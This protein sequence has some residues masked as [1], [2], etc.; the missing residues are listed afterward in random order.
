MKKVF[1]I[2]LGL[3]FT[4]LSSKEAMAQPT[5]TVT[6]GNSSSTVNNYTIPVNNF[7]NYSYT[8]QIY[9]ASELSR[10]L[11]GTITLI[12]FYWTGGSSGLTNSNNWTI[13]MGHTT[14]TAFSSSTVDWVPNTALTQVFQGTVSV[15]NTNGWVS[16]LLD[17][18]FVYNGTDNLVVAAMETQNGYP[19]TASTFR[20]TS[21]SVTRAMAY[22]S[23]PTP[24]TATNPPTSSNIGRYSYFNN[25]QFEFVVPPNNTG[26]T[27]FVNPPDTFCS[28][29][30]EVKV[31]VHNFGSNIVN[32]VKV[33]WKLNGVIQ[34]TINYST[35]ID[36]EN[37]MAGPDASITLATVNFP[38]ATPVNIQ[39]WTFEPNGVQDTNK[40]NDSTSSSISAHL[41][42][43]NDFSITP[44][45]T[46]IC[47][48]TVANLDAGDHPKNPI[49]I[50][51][52]G[53]ITR[54]NPVGTA[55]TYSVIVQNTDGCF[56]YDTVTV[57]YHDNPIAH[58]IAIE[59]LGNR[60]FKFQ[61]L[62]V[63]NVNIYEW[64]FGD[65]TAIQ[66]GPGAKVHTYADDG[67]YT[68][69][70]TLKN[71][72]NELVIS[73]LMAVGGTGVNDLNL[74]A[75]SIK[76]YPNPSRD[77]VTIA[78]NNVANLKFEY[79]TIYDLLGKKVQDFKVD[80]QTEIKVSGLN[81]G[82]YNIVIGTNQGQVSKKVE[83]IK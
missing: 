1:T 19:G 71:D 26:V 49:Y 34:P 50:W 60:T 51:S 59:D 46:T 54:Q 52:N 82:L 17:M 14:K 53:V 37:T 30:Q 38:Y 81:A 76:V 25:A 57:T 5:A 8:Q 83:I 10:P 47:T 16:I 2:G 36:M 7:Y 29:P 48:G 44:G 20:T 35:P 61:L 39:A 33:G 75:S 40:D 68:A 73:K 70:V 42:G 45:D 12:R 27:A 64:D 22:Y 32:N 65:Q 6:V 78:A 66:T 79:V 72:C 13:F 56:A 21:A 18:P 58:S 80:G 11:G 4:F 69:T 62:G 63:Q 43:I 31:N 15:T 55:G 77:I 23:D 28:G 41:L 3:L 24:P 74:K 67:V 9:Y